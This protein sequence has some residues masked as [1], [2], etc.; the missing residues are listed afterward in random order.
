VNIRI[1]EGRGAIEPSSEFEDDGELLV[2][3]PDGG[4]SDGFKRFVTSLAESMKAS[5]EWV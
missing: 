3:A 4:L 1:P 2:Y 5:V